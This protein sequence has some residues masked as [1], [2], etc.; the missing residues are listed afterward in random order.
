M[1]KQTVSIEKPAY[2]SVRDKQLIIKKESAEEI[3]VPEKSVEGRI[4]NDAIFSLSETLRKLREC[5]S[6]H[7]K[8]KIVFTAKRTGQYN[9][10]YG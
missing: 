9:K 1:I 3:S 2:L 8:S 7:D 5:R 4:Y 10:D 6:A